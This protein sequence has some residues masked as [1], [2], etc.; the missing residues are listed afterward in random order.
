VSLPGVRIEEAEQ[1]HPETVEEVADVLARAS[2][3]R[4]K[5]LVWGGGT[6]QGI[7]YPVEPD[8]VLHTD[9][10]HRLID[11]EPDDLTVVVE[12]GVGVEELEARLASHRQ[13]AALSEDAGPAT[14]GGALAAGISGYRRA[15][16][17]PTRDR[18]LEV[19]LVTGDGRVVRGGGRVVKNVSG[20]DLPRVA[21]GSLGSLGV[22]SSVCFKLWPLP[23]AN[24]TVTIDRSAPIDVYRPLAVLDDGTH[25]RVF[26]AGTEAEVDAQRRRLAGD[27]VQG[28]IWPEPPDGAWCLSL[29]MPPSQAPALLTRLPAHVS[30]LHQV[31]VGETAIASDTLDGMEALRKAAEN[32]GGSLVVTKAADDS[33][34]PWGT[35]PSALDLQR[36]LVAAFD[37][38]RVLNPG[39][40][41]GRI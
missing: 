39:R 4:K 32:A 5:V 24:A 13:T 19:Q 15:R 2:A 10:L 37:P 41:P 26:L 23:P 35:P 40:L 11:W 18:V 6:H 21:V 12:G 38:V 22:I 3:N 34:D 20:Y 9:G 16:F 30:Y 27:A 33:F 7:G 25:T 17:G 36:R 29:R 28:L 31:G 1:V 14:V 8:L